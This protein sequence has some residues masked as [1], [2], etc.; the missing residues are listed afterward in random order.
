MLLG[1]PEDDEFGDNWEHLL[2]MEKIL[3]PDPGQRFPQCIKGKRACPP[4]DVGGTWGY[5][6]FL[7]AL[8]DPEHPEHDEYLEWIGGKFDPEAFDL[9]RINRELHSL[10]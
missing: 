6:E 8:R 10:H 1:D 4:E 2:L 9:E 5:E 3:P 7:E